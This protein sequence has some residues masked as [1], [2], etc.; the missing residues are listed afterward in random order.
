LVGYSWMAPFL[1]LQKM[2]PIEAFSRLLGSIFLLDFWK[3]PGNNVPGKVVERAS[4]EVREAL[5]QLKS[6]EL[7]PGNRIEEWHKGDDDYYKNQEFKKD[8]LAFDKK[9]LK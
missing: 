1:E 8:R 4:P 2:K 3:R 5:S 6:D 7:G 9:I